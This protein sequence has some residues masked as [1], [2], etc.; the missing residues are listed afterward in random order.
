MI[1]IVAMTLVGGLG[2][3][4]G[5]IVGAFA[6][7]LGVESLRA[8]GDYR[9]VIYGILIILVIMFLPR[10]LASAWEMLAQ[11]RFDPKRRRGP[12]TGT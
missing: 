4:L 2:T 11:R 1:L 6:L 3:L 10:G 5:P 9:L 8:V 12:G 7:T